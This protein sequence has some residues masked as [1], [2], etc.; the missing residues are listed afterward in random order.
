M[1]LLSS[2]NTLEEVIVE[3][4]GE[5][6]QGFSWDVFGQCA[7]KPVTQI[8]KVCSCNL[9]MF[10]E[11]DVLLEDFPG[12]FRFQLTSKDEL[13]MAQVEDVEF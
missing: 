9:V 6:D 13:L 12:G 7:A 2:Y 4:F 8:V 10:T 11:F 5:E 3:L 1:R